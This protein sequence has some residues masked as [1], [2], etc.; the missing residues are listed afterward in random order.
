M[1]TCQ[2][3]RQPRRRSCNHR[4]GRIAT[5][6]VPLEEVL[7]ENGITQEDLTQ[8]VQE[9]PKFIPPHHH[10]DPKADENFAAQGYLTCTV[11]GCTSVD[12]WIWRMPEPE[13]VTLES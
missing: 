12:G 5:H 1:L 2:P 8:P 9:R 7:K 4:Q 6:L 3:I 10:F 13:E 11:C